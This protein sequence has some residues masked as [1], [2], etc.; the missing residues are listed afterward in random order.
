VTSQ[1]F[2][3]VVGGG[4]T[5]RPALSPAVIVEH[6]CIDPCTSI[7]RGTGLRLTVNDGRTATT[8]GTRKA[9]L[10]IH[11][12]RYIHTSVQVLDPVCLLFIVA[13][14]NPIGRCMKR[15]MNFHTCM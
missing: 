12:Y 6:H 2:Y 8:A 11:R 15:C 4:H 9:Y 10:C 1:A 13:R 3:R 7:A 5:L 14:I